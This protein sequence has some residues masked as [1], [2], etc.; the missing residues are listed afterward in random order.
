[1]HL[2]PLH[3]G[4]TI[5]NPTSSNEIHTMSIESPLSKR[6]KRHVIG[7]RRSYFVAASPGFEALCYREL[8]DLGLSLETVSVVE[9]GVEFKGQLLDCYQANLHLR[10]ASRILL[11]IDRFKASDFRQ[12]EKKVAGI[13]WE[14]YLPPKMLPD[15]HVT[16]KHCRLYHTD[17][18]GQRFLDGI[19]MHGSSGDY[20]RE[21]INLPLS[22]PTVFVRGLDDRF[23]ISIDSSGSHLHK[24][25]LK[26]H[27]GKA[28]LRE[29]MAA[30]A[31]LLVG[32]N[33]TEP[34]IDPMCGTGTFSLE[35]ALMAKK[36]PPGWFRE[37]AFMHWPSFSQKRWDY[38]KRRSAEQFACPPGPLIF[39][40]DQDSSACSRL[41]RCIRQNHLSEIITVSRKNFFDFLPAELTDQTGVV[42]INPPYGIRLASLEKSG[43]LFLAI[44][45]KL[46]QAY[47]G[48]K[49]VLVAP[50]RKLIKKMPFKLDILPFFHG[51]LKPALMFGKVT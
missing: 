2:A 9:G 14:L 11:R 28:P 50:D 7:R 41:D 31:L 42:V 12:L 36:I 48:W 38:L 16:T 10:T 40:S 32:Y 22:N 34:L 49:L 33:G 8:S 19:A 1:L 24:R 51:G 23:S 35:A 17:A 18:I 45:D 4:S 30:A 20:S 25:G 29:T 5:E 44:C 43:A 6:I 15:I 26:R 27:H 47:T 21:E 39:A 3:K 13:P 37:F 46:K